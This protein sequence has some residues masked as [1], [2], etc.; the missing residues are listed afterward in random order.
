MRRLLLPLL[1][2]RTAW[3]NERAKQPALRAVL[4]RLLPLLQ[5]LLLPA[6]TRTA[7]A[8]EQP[9]ARLRAVLW[10]LLLPLLRRLLLRLRHLLR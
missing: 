10:R 1:S 5:R 9:T 2:A 3:A 7:W 6:F 4:W 8:N